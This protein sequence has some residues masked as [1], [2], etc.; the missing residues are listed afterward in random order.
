MTRETIDG[1]VRVWDGP[2]VKSRGRL[3]VRA[4]SEGTGV[5]L[6]SG[7]FS[8][9][10]L[11]LSALTASAVTLI[12]GSLAPQMGVRVY[13]VEATASCETGSGAAEASGI[14]PG[15]RNLEL[16]VHIE[17]SAGDEAVG[18]LLEAWKEASPVYSA[19]FRPTTLDVSGRA[20]DWYGGN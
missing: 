8:A 1:T 13:S 11:V 19:L 18:R 2:P 7:A 20:I 15:L 16:D 10:A 12:K 14:E 3:S 6:E 17:T 4:R 5:R 9:N